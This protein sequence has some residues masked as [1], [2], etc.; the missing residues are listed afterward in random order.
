MHLRRL[1][2]DDAAVMRFTEELWLP[3]HRELSTTVEAHALCENEGV[4]TGASEFTTEFLDSTERHCW[5]AID[6]VSDP[7]VSIEDIDGTFAGF[8]LAGVEPSPS[9]FE[10]PDRFV[11]GDFYVR[12]SYR[13]T[14]LAQRLVGRGL[15]QAREEGCSELVLDVDVDNERALA[16]YEKLGFEPGRY[17]MRCPV[18][19]IDLGQ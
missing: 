15:T 13:G 9:T 16:F 19:D 3:Y 18:S 14:G 2:P 5:I 8:L 4:V 6:D 10:W 17:R 1:R 7:F 12:D 11:L